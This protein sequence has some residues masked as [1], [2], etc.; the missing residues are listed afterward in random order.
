VGLL[1][2]T[3]LREGWPRITFAQGADAVFRCGV[4]RGRLV[5]RD[6]PISGE[7]F[8]PAAIESMS[9]ALEGVCADRW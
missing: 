4:P 5:R 6:H 1:L 8:D 2:G 9:R 7:A 3:A